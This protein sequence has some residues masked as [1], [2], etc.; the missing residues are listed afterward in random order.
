MWVPLNNV[1]DRLRNLVVAR[2]ADGR[3]E[4]FGTAADDSIWHIWRTAPNSGWSAWTPFHSGG[5]RLRQL[6]VGQNLDG[7]LEVFGTAGDDTIWH[8]W[9]TAP[10]NGWRGWAQFHSGGDHLRTLAVGRNADGRLEVFGT[11]A[12]DSIWHTWQT[13]PNNGWSGWAQLFGPGDRL[14]TLDVAS[15]ADGRLEVFGT[16]GDN[17]IW[18]T[19]QTAPSN[20]WI[21]DTQGPTHRVDV[22]VILVGHDV[23]TAADHA[24]TDDAMSRARDIFAQVGLDLREVGRFGITAAQAGANLTIDSNAEASDLTSDWT[25]HNAA[26]DLF[27]VRVMNGAEGWS[28]VNGSCDKDVKGMTGSVV[29]LN[30][31]AANRGNTFAHEMGH[32]MG[33]NHIPDNGN[34]IGN[35]GSSNS[36]T[37][38]FDWQGN[39]MKN[40]CFV[41][42]L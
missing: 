34:F 4:V 23:F 5:D 15:N 21:S 16:A 32:Y 19:W 40:H 28:A 42:K 35:N 26:L 27:V 31:T 39:T 22:N 8:T 37:G 1:N 12:D 24:N 17:T 18:H 13:A 30:G 9:Q 2:N 3:L 38:I 29:S 6:V 20:G 33:L 36:F 14:H 7:R 10:N 25:V 11:A 41:Q